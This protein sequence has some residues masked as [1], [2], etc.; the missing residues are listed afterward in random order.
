MNKLLPLLVAAAFLTIFP[1]K[2]IAGCGQ[3]YRQ[4]IVH[5]AHV[6]QQVL[7]FAGQAVQDEAIVRKAIRAELPAIVD[8]VRQELQAPQQQTLGTLGQ[9]CAK[10]HTGETAQG[11]FDLKA[12]IDDGQ[13]RR[14]VEMLGAG[15]DVPEAM[16]AVVNSLTP[17]QKGAITDEMLSLPTVRPVAPP[18]PDGELR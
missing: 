18:V 14:I 10:C 17:E 1:H 2:G 13:F 7:Y 15:R 16:K 4:K 6:Q 3:L 5:H 11:G 9:K 8:A 12:G